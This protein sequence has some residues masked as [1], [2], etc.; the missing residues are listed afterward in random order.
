MMTRGRS[1][2]IEL[3]QLVAKTLHKSIHETKYKQLSDGLV[4]KEIPNHLAEN[5]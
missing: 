5:L 3:I 2:Q 4:P 1:S